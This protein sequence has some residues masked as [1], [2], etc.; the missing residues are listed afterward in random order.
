[1]DAPSMLYDRQW[2]TNEGREAGDM[3]TTE[4]GPTIQRRA[5]GTSRQR[6]VRRREID[7]AEMALRGLYDRGVVMVLSRNAIVQRMEAP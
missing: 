7:R 6:R 4:Q 3:A 1:M 2:P 5:Q